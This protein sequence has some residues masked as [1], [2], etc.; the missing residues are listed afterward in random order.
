MLLCLSRFY[1]YSDLLSV[2][3]M[4]YALSIGTK[5]IIVSRKSLVL[6]DNTWE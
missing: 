3:A 4:A 6:C 2:L 1:K 5:I